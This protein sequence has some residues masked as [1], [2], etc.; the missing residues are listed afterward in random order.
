MDGV[1]KQVRYKVV[2][3]WKPGE[4]GNPAGRPKK[5]KTLLTIL[6]G[7]LKKH[8]QIKGKRSDKTWEELLAQAWLFG[9][10]TKPVLLQM[11]LERVYGKVEDRIDVTTKGESLN[12]GKHDIA[13]TIIDEAM[14]ILYAAGC[15]TPALG[16]NCPAKN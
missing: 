4:S 3:R 16:D 6:E 14:E 9:S 2:P 12:D 1:V 13:I 5:T 10:L 11:L 7:E 8:P 15:D